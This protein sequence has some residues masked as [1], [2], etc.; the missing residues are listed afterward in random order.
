[1]PFTYEQL[2][3]EKKILIDQIRKS[4]SKDKILLELIFDTKSLVKSISN[5]PRPS[6]F[7]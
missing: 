1:M 5:K 7:P 4:D 6:E 3:K 2:I